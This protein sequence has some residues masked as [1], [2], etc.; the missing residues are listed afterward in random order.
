[1]AGQVAAS[2]E[3]GQLILFHHDPAYADDCV[4]AQEAAAKNIFPDSI[5]AYEGLEISLNPSPALG[6]GV[7]VREGVK[8]AAHD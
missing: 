3:T 4:T 8:Y 2:A 7:G 6:R 5:A 1:M